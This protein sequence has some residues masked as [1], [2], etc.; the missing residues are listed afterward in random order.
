MTGRRG[1]R[2]NY[3]D[4]GR[5]LREL[6]QDRSLRGPLGDRGGAVVEPGPLRGRTPAKRSPLRINVPRRY[7]PNLE[8]LSRCQRIPTEQPRALAVPAQVGGI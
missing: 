2:G 7:D 4:F 1:T 6:P 5:I 3:V 8:T